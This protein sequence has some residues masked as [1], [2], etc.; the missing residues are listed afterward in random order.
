MT[1]SSSESSAPT[2]IS[3]EH[4]G[5][6]YNGE[7]VR[8]ETWHPSHGQP[9]KGDTYFRV[10]FVES[11][12]DIFPRSLH[13]HRIA[14]YV[15]GHRSAELE[16]AEVALR[17]LRE[18]MGTYATDTDTF[19]MLSSESRDIED[20]AID[21]WADSFRGGHLISAPLL[22]ANL[23][24][25]FADGY[26]STWA[27]RIGKLLLDR[28]YPTTP[29]KA[30]LLQMPIRPDADA[31][32]ILDAALTSAS[33]TATLALGAFGP[34]L[35][36]SSSRAPRVADV[37]KSDVIQRLATMVADGWPASDIGRALAH[38]L[39]LTYPLA[40][41]YLLLWISVGQHSV[42]L[43]PGHGL[44]HRDGTPLETDAIGPDD[45]ANLRWPVA[46]WERID[47]I[48]Q[49]AAPATADP[50][51][52]ALAG[53]IGR[54]EDIQAAASRRIGELQDDLPQVTH[55]LTRIATAQRTQDL[56]RETALLRELASADSVDT[57]L[58]TARRDTPTPVVFAATMALWQA[59][60][61][62][63]TDAPALVA[64]AAWID[65]AT[66]DESSFDTYTE[67][68]VL[69]ERLNNPRLLTSPHEWAALAESVRL[70]QHRYAVA[71]LR[72]HREYHTQVGALAHA[73]EAA[74]RKAHALERL[75][76]VA[77]LGEPTGFGLPA[78]ADEMRN[79]VAACGT[80][81]EIA[82][83]ETTPMC[84]SCGMHLGA[85][86]PTAEVNQLV[87]YVDEALGEQ[88][89]RLASAIAQRVLNRPGVDQI[90]RFIQVV[91]VSD[92]SGL[93]HVLDD[94]VVGFITDLL[95]Q[96]QDPEATR[97]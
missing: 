19:D 17:S 28:A 50:Y 53:Q 60:S 64:A 71:Y 8:T 14:V 91:Q 9:L 27:E 70:F 52:A 89:R 46:L 48:S 4:R 44:V 15:P 85:T 33:A 29:I 32:I 77:A 80:E 40:T 22:D 83:I 62:A 38:E 63:E 68:Q 67:R 94:A 31:P 36:L 73:V 66:I 90:D 69:S 96:P 1:L 86:P 54:N 21:A 65:A 72:D 51:L 23:E 16:R 7:V 13:D 12:T 39:G 26:W 57:A 20:R 43:R 81:R 79:A 92:L 6:V 84:P 49:D 34:A 75:N 93:A 3:V 5:V 41:A 95:D 24:A 74:W 61:D 30:E 56:P 97:G 11:P 37:A 87:A 88:N 55:M 25:I 10:V 58:V 45:I 47:A 18:A 76:T 2:T 42:R 78:L 82:D 59:W 35:G